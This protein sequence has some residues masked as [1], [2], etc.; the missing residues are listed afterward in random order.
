MY[1][2]VFLWY[3]TYTKS[4]L[5]KQM[6]IFKIG[7][8]KKHFDRTE[9]PWKTAWYIRPIEWALMLYFKAIARFKI[10]KIGIKGTK[11]PYL[12]LQNHTSFIDF[13]FTGYMLWPRTT[14]FVC[15]IEEFIGKEWLLREVGCI[16]KRKFTPDVNV[17][18]HILHVLKKNKQSITIY[19]EARFSIAGI[20]EEGDLSSYARLIKLCKVPVI[21]GIGEGSFIYSPQFAKHPYKKIPMR[22]TYKLI[23]NE[24]QTQTLSQEEIEAILKENFVYDDYKYWQENGFKVKSKHRAKN[25]HKV[26]YQCPH[27]KKEFSMNSNGNKLFCEECKKEWF[28]NENGYLEA[29]GGETEFTHVPDWYKWE[30]ENV[31]KQIEE[32][33]YSVTAPARLEK[34]V[35]SAVGFKK[36]GDVNFKHDKNGFTL[37]GTLDDGSE[38]NFNRPVDSMYSCHIEYD[39]KG[40]GDAIDLADVDETYFVYPQLY[41]HLT[42]IHLATEEMFKYYKD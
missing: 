6:S 24:E 32:G 7:I 19:P 10:K 8:G 33:T 23:I 41:N 2:C 1:I 27:C 28:L 11:G 40:R 29:V 9:K 18:K 39:F 31:R 30:R 14:A 15:S 35:S 16:Y 17:V 5:E 13:I 22:A 21:M 3:T 25:L 12:I 26:L 36:I 42:K 34:I 4:L 20:T 38:F 37:S